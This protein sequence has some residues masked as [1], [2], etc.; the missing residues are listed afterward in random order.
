MDEARRS[1]FARAGAGLASW[2]ASPRAGRR[3][4]RQDATTPAAPRHRR[5]PLPWRRRPPRGDPPPPPGAP[6]VGCAGARPVLR[7]HADLLRERRA[8]RRA[9]LPDGDRRRAG[10]LAPAAGR[11]HLLPHRHRRARPEGGPVGRGGRAQP[12]WSRPTATRRASGPP[13]TA[14]TSPTTTSSAPPSPATT[15]R[16]RRCSSG[17]RTTATSSSTPTRAPTACPA[18]PTTRRAS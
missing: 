9:R 17:S 12:R 5:R 13:G 18:R 6:P 15:P 10:P 1:A 4:R 14:S 16:C 2:P 11:R 8:P 3:R 7:H